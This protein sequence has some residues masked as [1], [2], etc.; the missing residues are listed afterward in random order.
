MSA[1]RSITDQ[2][3]ADFERDGFVKLPQILPSEWVDRLR[4]VIQTLYVDGVVRSTE[5]ETLE[6][7]ANA[8][9][10]DLLSDGG[11]ALTGRFCFSTNVWKDHPSLK[12]LCLGAPLPELAAQL[13]R[14]PKVNFLIDQIFLK[15]P[16][17]A[18]RTAF[19]QDESYFNCTGEQC[20]TFWIP[21]DI[22]DKANGAM[23]YV[24][25]SHLWGRQFAANMFVSQTTLPGSA[26]E[27][28]PDIEGNEEK[29]GVRY[30][31]TVPGDII[32][33]H[34]RTLHG[35][36][37]NTDPSRIRRAAALRYGGADLRYHLRT[38]A[39]MTSPSLREGDVM[40]SPE[41][42]IVWEDRTPVA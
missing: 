4:E 3:I 9:G 39:D 38:Q 18:R 27:R 10:D 25:G 30:V 16:G 26:G 31:E 40:D 37:G 36:T 5:A 21:V 22:V 12:A 33:H 35:S 1:L 7:L 14:S 41:F 8:A 29:Y 19:H 15:E 42:P 2:E 34:Y 32:V 20:A 24:P 23:G 13:Y 11:S 28:I 17:A 6:K